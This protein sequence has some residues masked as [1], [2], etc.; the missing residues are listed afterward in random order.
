MALVPAIG[1]ILSL[2][3]IWFYNLSETRYLEIVEELKAHKEKEKG[4]EA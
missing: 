4:I 2:I 3:T 1:A